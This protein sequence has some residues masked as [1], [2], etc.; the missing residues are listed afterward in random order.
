MY[1]VDF[2]IRWNDIDAN[3][4]MA[5]S[6]YISFMS[7]TRICFLSE[8]GLGKE[9]LSENEIGPVVFYEHM[10]Y[11]KEVMLGD[12]IQV[13]LELKGMSEDGLFYEF[14]HNFYDKDGKNIASCEMMGSWID[15]KERKLKALNSTL[16]ENLKK[17]GKTADFKILTKEDTRK[18][19]KKPINLV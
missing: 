6:A 17:L 1:L 13:S 7:H 11:F 4:H 12:T 3:W 9:I 2:N 14:L 19:A 16:L 5:N 8:N 18:F 10:Y 15:L